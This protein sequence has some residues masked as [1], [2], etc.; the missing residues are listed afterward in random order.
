MV[1]VTPWTSYTVN[2]MRLT[3][4]SVPADAT[5]TIARGGGAVSTSIPS[6]GQNARL[7]FSGTSGQRVSLKTTGVT[8]GGSTIVTIYNPNNT[9]LASTNVTANPDGYI[10][11][12]TLPTTGTYTILIDPSATNTGNATV[13]LY[14]VV[15]VTNSIT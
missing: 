13:T 4:Y 2:S 14:D 3:A 8:I 15:D 7:S 10:D 12:I 1:M 11:A 5:G 6:L 9:I